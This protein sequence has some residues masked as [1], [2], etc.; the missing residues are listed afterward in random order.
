MGDILLLSAHQRSSS[1]LTQSMMGF[2]K[3]HFP[4]TGNPGALSRQTVGV[5]NAVFSESFCGTG[6]Q[7][8]LL[9][10]PPALN[11][12]GCSRILWHS[13]EKINAEGFATR[14]GEINAFFLSSFRL[15]SR[16]LGPP[17]CAAPSKLK[18]TFTVTEKSRWTSVCIPPAAR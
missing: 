16:I 7:T 12:R 4:H 10:P 1:P 13:K 17:R 14:D 15:A 11:P 8:L 3:S 6:S 5:I 2:R 18:P 9:F